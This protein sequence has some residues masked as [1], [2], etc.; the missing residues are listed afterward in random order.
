M[1]GAAAGGTWMRV[2]VDLRSEYE[3]WA[4]AARH[5]AV[6]AEQFPY[7]KFIVTEQE[8]TS[9]DL[10]NAEVYFGWRF[11]AEAFTWSPSLRCRWR[12]TD[13]STRYRSA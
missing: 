4:F 11:P 5:R 8:G 3:F 2:V 13:Y 1:V 9:A 7:A 6:L 12:T 10:A